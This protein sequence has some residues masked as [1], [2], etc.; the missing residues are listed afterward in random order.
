M[1]EK[2]KNLKNKTINH[3]NRNRGKYGIVAGSGATLY[4]LNKLDRVAKWNEFLEEHDL[5]DAFYSPEI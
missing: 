3:V 5:T 1:P 4:V 2:I